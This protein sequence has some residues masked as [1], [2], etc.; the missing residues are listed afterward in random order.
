MDISTARYVGASPWSADPAGRCLP[1]TD[2]LRKFLAARYD[3]ADQLGC[4]ASRP[5]T[6]GSSPS[7][8]RDGRAFDLG[9]LRDE[10]QRQECF[11]FL[12]DNAGALGVQMVLNYARTGSEGSGRYWRLARYRDENAPEFGSW[13]K[14]GHWLHVEIHPS[15]ALDS[16]PIAQL[17]GIEEPSPAPPHPTDRKEITVNVTLEQ[18]R[19]GDRGG[20]VKKAQSIMNANFGQDISADGIFGPRTDQAVRNVQTFFSLEVDGICGPKTWT[21]LLEVAPD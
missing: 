10:G 5:V 3:G 8:H 11:V 20:F 16:T 7:V 2:L 12:V 4:Y 18:V 6:G 13:S 17:L 14:T 1:R 9:F 15:E 19:R 21:T